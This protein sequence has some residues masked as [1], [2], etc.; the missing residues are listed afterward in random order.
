MA[1]APDAS[2][3]DLL[4]KLAV[5]HKMVTEQHVRTCLAAQRKG[6]NKPLGQLLVEHDFLTIGQL[7]Y[8]IKTQAER[9]ALED[10]RARHSPEEALFG[11]LAVHQG[12]ISEDQLAEAVSE[13][14][15]L[16]RLKI[17]FRLGEILVKKGHLTAH[18]VQVLLEIQNKRILLCRRCNCRFNIAGMKADSTFN[19]KFCGQPLE[20]LG[21]DDD[22]VVVK[23]SLRRPATEV[24]DLDDEALDA[25]DPDEIQLD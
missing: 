16:E 9:L 8:L 1:D 18:Q 23:E 19:C 20:P 14:A 22:S 13:K 24:S 10:E 12:L 7:N 25:V 2:P 17:R 15:N 3:P 5:K 11:K 4:G 21:P 6:E